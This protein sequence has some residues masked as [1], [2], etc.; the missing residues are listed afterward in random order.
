MA[1]PSQGA[2]VN[3]DFWPNDPNL[4]GFLPSSL[5]TYIRSLKV[6]KQIYSLYRAHGIHRQSAKV[7]LDLVPNDAK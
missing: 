2:K 7:D 6:I 4:I 5:T 3:L 1:S